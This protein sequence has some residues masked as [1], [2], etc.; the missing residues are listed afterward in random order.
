M[1]DLNSLNEAINRR[2]GRKLIPS[3]IV[4]LILL[5]LV[6]GTITIAPVTFAFLILAAILLAMRELVNAFRAGGIELPTFAMLL[7]AT[8]LL[9]ATWQGGIKGLSVATGMIVP[10]LLVFILIISPTGFIK[11][12]TAA[13]FGTF[14]L[15]FLA[16]FILLVAHHEQAQE[17]ILLLVLC[18]A[19]NDTFAYLFGVL[20]GKHKL[21]PHISPKKSWEGLI[22][23]LTAE[24]IGIALVM[25]YIF[26]QPVWVG[27]VLGAASTISATCGD[28]IESAMKRDL[29]IKDMS[30]F[31]PGHGGMLDRIDSVLFVAPTVWFA[32]ELI[33]KYL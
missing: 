21:A 17:R 16:G 25:F 10:I 30:N 6:F 8:I 26:H 5:A 9:T 22:G 12:S 18:V 7:V 11:R 24:L 31:L 27:L 29:T 19:L 3:I 14:Y 15:P 20:F 4:S 2:A 23:G 28:L 32:L 33:N 13:V 1:T